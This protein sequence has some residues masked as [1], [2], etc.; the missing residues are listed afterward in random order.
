MGRIEALRCWQHA[1]CLC[2]GVLAQFGMSEDGL[3]DGDSSPLHSSPPARI[4]RRV[5][6]LVAALQPAML[7]VHGLSH[8]EAP[9][10]LPL[11]R[12][13][14]QSVQR[15]WASGGAKAPQSSSSTWLS[16]SSRMVLFLRLSLHGASA[17]VCL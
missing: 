6:A 2:L 4:A 17:R 5:R 11:E 14:K 15:G 13:G 3:G 12:V 8:A 7:A 16:Q 9:R 1:A 10:E